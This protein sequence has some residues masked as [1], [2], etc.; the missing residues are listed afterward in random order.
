MFVKLAILNP[1]DALIAERGNA[2]V[3]SVKLAK[4][5]AAHRRISRTG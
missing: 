2:I 4:R 1:Q 5:V 3:W